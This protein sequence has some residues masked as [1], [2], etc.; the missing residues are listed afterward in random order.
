MR[1]TDGTF[2]C[3]QDYYDEND[4][5]DTD[6]IVDMPLEGEPD[7]GEDDGHI[8]P[9]EK[10]NGDG[11]SR[12]IVTPGPVEESNTEDREFIKLSSESDSSE[13]SEN[14]LDGND[15]DYNLADDAESDDDKQPKVWRVTVEQA[16][17]ETERAV[18]AA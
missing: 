2:D 12:V 6:D 3:G 14:G 11:V 16:K 4:D 1:V 13:N 15:P 8:T 17:S 7:D 5:E 10:E 9:D 18:R